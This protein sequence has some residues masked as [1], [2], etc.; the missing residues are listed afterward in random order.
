M[1][2]IVNNYCRTSHRD[3]LRILVKMHPI[4]AGCKIGELYNDKL[5]FEPEYTQKNIYECLNDSCVAFTASSSSSMDAIL[6]GTY[7]ICLSHTGQLYYT[8]IAPGIDPD[9]FSIVFDEDDFAKAMKRA[10]DFN[11]S[12]SMRSLSPDDYF[13]PANKEN[14]EP[15]FE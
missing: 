14:F 7:L 12:L 4:Y 3:G 8:C 6:N 15:L 11:K 9:R 1:I 2:R 10:E 13:I 5:F